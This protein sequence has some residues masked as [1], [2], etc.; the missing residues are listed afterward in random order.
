[1]GS[2][3]FKKE[4]LVSSTKMV[5]NF[6]S[7]LKQ[8]RDEMVDKFAILR[9]NEIEAVVIPI[10]EYERVQKIAEF[11]EHIDIYSL[12]K[13]REKVSEDQY[14]DREAVLKE[15]GIDPGEI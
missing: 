11:M 10:D 6:G 5:K 12:I 3:M 15:L 13:E 14:L 7:F 1:M 2:V 4:E 9:N 8:L